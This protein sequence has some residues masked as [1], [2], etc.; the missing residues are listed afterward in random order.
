MHGIQ[1]VYPAP[2][3]QEAVTAVIAA[4]KA[5]DTGPKVRDDFRRV[6]D[7][8][9]ADGVPVMIAACTELSVICPDL[10]HVVDA[11]DALVDAVIQKARG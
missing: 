2:A 9:T 6:I 8:M 5:G 4:V 7:G 1:A 10:P 11:L 3:D